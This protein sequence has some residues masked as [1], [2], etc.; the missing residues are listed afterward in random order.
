MGFNRPICW[1]FWAEIKKGIG[2]IFLDYKEACPG[3]LLSKIARK[4]QF[5]KNDIGPPYCGTGWPASYPYTTSS[6][7]CSSHRSLPQANQHITTI[8]L[9][10]TDR[11]TKQSLPLAKLTYLS[12]EWNVG[13]F[14]RFKKMCTVNELFSVLNYLK[15][16]EFKFF[17]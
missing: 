15:I 12:S 1:P 9:K 3:F 13:W 11:P 14:G 10:C 4:K 6:H 8:D 17:H 16:F 7:Y 2:I 5:S